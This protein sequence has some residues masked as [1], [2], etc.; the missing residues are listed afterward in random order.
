MKPTAYRVF[1]KYRVGARVHIGL[2]IVDARTCEIADDVRIGHGNL[3]IQLGSLFL[4]HHVR[5]GQFNIIRGGSSVVVKPF[6]DIRRMNEINAIV[7]PRVENPVDQT[8]V[9]GTGSTLTSGHKIDFTDR[10]EIGRMTVLGGRH[11]SL[12]THARQH[13]KPVTIGA[14]CYV[15]SEIRMAPGSSIPARSIVGMGAVVVSSFEDEETLIVG[16]PAKATR[17]L[18][19]EDRALLEWVPRADL[20]FDIMFGTD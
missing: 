9:L 13:T 7:D 14:W 18:E 4:G 3:L 16:V 8:F 5:I 2:S 17:R 15:G 20:P 12:W 11:S 10:V 1:F 19:E 6:A